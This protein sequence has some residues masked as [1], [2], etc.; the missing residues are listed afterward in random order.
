MSA[1]PPPSSPPGAPASAGGVIL[2]VVLTLLG[3]FTLALS[4]TFQRYGLGAPTRRIPLF[5]GR[6]PRIHHELVWFFGL[7]LYGVANGLKVAAAPLAPWSILSSV[8]TML[9]VFN[10][11]I[12]RFCLGELPTWPKVCGALAILLGAVICVLGT[13]L[14]AADIQWSADEFTTGLVQPAALTWAI[15]LFGAVLLSI[16][17][18]ICYERTYARPYLQT[19]GS[20]ARAA[21]AGVAGAVAAPD[22]GE[23]TGA[24]VVSSSADKPMAPASLDRLMLLVYAC[25]LGLDEGVADLLLPKGWQA[26]LAVCNNPA[27]PQHSC[28]HP[29]IWITMGLWV[30]SAFA[31]TFWWMRKVFARYETTIALPI[32]VRRVC[33]WN[34]G[35]ILRR[36]ELWSVL[37]C[38]LTRFSHS[39]QYGALNFANVCTGLL[40][41]AE[42]ELMHGWQ[43]ALVI[44]GCIIILIGIAI[45][46]IQPKRTD[47]APDLSTPSPQAMEAA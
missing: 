36:L 13:P 12:A 16:P 25:S 22:G 44:T 19:D 37:T 47:G 26:M 32:E 18:I 20:A 35:A 17:T 7:V 29:M 43:L 3:A 40:F 39:P 46:Q 1:T 11:V 31:S 15:L 27:N 8:W 30:L 45:G 10:L 6:G 23:A 4:M 2:G 9:L 28:A 38:A 14:A 21:A 33:A 42:H 34:E 41:F 5:F 24:K